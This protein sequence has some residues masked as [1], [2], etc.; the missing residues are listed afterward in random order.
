LAVEATLRGADGGALATSSATVDVPTGAIGF[1]VDALRL[2]L[3]SDLA[4]G[5]YALEVVARGD[6]LEAS[7]VRDVRVE[8]EADAFRR[9]VGRGLVPTALETGQALVSER[10][11]ALGE[12]ALLDRLVEELQLAAP[13]AGDVL[14][15]IEEGR[16]AGLDGGEAFAASG[17]ADAAAFLAHLLATDARDASFAFVDAYAQWIVDGAPEAP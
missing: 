8:G 10:D 15:T 1:V 6:G 14:P 5:A 17:P 3:P 4:A 7:A 13:F 11:L 2:E 9:L 16:F 12:A